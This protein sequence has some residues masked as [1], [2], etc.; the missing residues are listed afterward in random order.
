MKELKTPVRRIW[1]VHGFDDSYARGRPLPSLPEYGNIPEVNRD[2]DAV[3]HTWNSIQAEITSLQKQVEDAEKEITALESEKQLISEMQQLLKDKPKPKRKSKSKNPWKGEP[4][5]EGFEILAKADLNT[6]S[7]H[8]FTPISVFKRK[9]QDPYYFRRFFNPPPVTFEWEELPETPAEP[10][11]PSKT[12]PSVQLQ[13][14]L[15]VVYSH[16]RTLKAKIIKL[17]S[18]ARKMC[19]LQPEV[20]YLQACSEFYLGR[21]Q[22]ETE[23]RIA[24][25]QAKVF[26][27]KMGPTVNEREFEKE[28]LEL[29]E[30]K[31]MAEREQML[32]YDA[33]AGGREASPGEKEEKEGED[34]DETAAINYNPDQESD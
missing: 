21:Q 13:E 18:K 6:T 16:R 29:K 14:K 1:E 2:A 24:M 9:S 5:P 30:W 31:V 28:H 20:A 26:R 11:L 10:L 12:H 4:P 19:R 3:E 33:R 23:T 22:E 7:L 34:Y 25:E 32:I 17:E 27:R 15:D 8:P